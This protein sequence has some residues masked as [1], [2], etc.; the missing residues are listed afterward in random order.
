MDSRWKGN[1]NYGYD[2]VIGEI[3]ASV[4]SGGT[5][6]R[7]YYSGSVRTPFFPHQQQDEFFSINEA[8]AWCEQW[9]AF[10]VELKQLRETVV[11]LREQ[12]QKDFKEIMDLREELHDYR[13]P[14]GREVAS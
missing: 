9:I 7:R 10:A 13:N 8:T 2:L 12:R 3:I 5:R 11:I 6:N 14:H 1:N 4:Y